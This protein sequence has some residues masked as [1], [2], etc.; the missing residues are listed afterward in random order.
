MNMLF[1]PIDAFSALNVDAWK[2]SPQHLTLPL[3]GHRIPQGLA[4]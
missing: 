4:P 1:R 2:E 3:R